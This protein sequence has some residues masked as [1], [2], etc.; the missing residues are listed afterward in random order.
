MYYFNGKWA[1]FNQDLQNFPSQT[2]YNI[3]IEPPGPLAFRHTA[4]LITE[5]HSVIDHPSL[6]YN[7]DT[8][9][10]VGQF[11]TSPGIYNNN[12]VGIKYITNRWCI[13]NMNGSPI[14]FNSKYNIFID[15]KIFQAGT[16]TPSSG[17]TNASIINN[18]LLDNHPYAIVFNTPI[19]NYYS[20]HNNF[21]TGVKYQNNHWYISNPTAA[22][23][24]SNA[25]FNIFS[26]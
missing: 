14:P 16:I 5:G 8:K 13:V 6:N 18:N 25:R 9:F 2:K 26:L 3:L 7:R 22:L 23:L 10:I 19:K 17:I 24:G 11:W 20:T 1:I 4:T 12:P 21:E 15:Y